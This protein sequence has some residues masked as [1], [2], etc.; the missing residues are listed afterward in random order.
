MT[1]RWVEATVDALRPLADPVRAAPMRSY[2]KDI[3]PFLGVSTPDRRRALRGAW[4]GLAPL[5]PPGLAIAARRLWSMP[6]REFHYAACDMIGRHQRI[7][8]AAFLLDPLRELITT[9]AW[10]DTVDLLETDAVVPLVARSPEL[11]DVMWE[12]LAADD[13]WLVRTA[14]QHQRGRRDQTDVTRLY[15]MCDRVAAEREFFVA[16]AVGWALR[17]TC[18]WDPAG[19]RRFVDAHPDLSA[20][21]RREALKG[22]RRVEQLSCPSLP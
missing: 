5:D 15:A 6:E 8:P 11:V 21:A 19:V 9:H 13:R 16:K 20:V 1:D 4:T 22:L 7:L 10:W 18:R 17:D 14:I 12:W 3:A 2:M